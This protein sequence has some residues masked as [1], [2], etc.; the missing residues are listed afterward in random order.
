MR[1]RSFLT[2]TGACTAAGLA[3]LSDP[4]A[5]AA[6]AVGVKHTDL[7]DLTIR[8]VKIYNTDT[9][10]ARKLN[11][12]ETGELISIVTN[13]GHEGNF[14]IG[15]RAHTDNW[16]DWAKPALLGKN[17]NDL[18]P[19]ITATSGLKANYGYN[20]GPWRRPGRHGG[21]GPAR[22]GPGA[23][24]PAPGVRGGGTWPNYYSAVAEMA[25]WDLLGHVVDR[26]VYKI[27]GGTKD[28]MMAYAS[29]QHLP[30][31]E[32][33]EADIKQC[34]SEGYRGYKIHPGGGRA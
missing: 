33:Y 28:R 1:R 12:T 21:R 3:A 13:S 19:T 31:V 16:L 24:G 25:M 27:L 10:T 26:P 6:Q 22:G 34:I 30:F 2:A 23:G 32:D 9:G 29:S 14:T 4:G 17:V 18:L 8:E 5:A 7:P 11:G 20:C 15:N